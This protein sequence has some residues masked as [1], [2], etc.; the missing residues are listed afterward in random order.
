MIQEYG[1]NRRLWRLDDSQPTEYDEIQGLVHI[2]SGKLLR[3]PPSEVA[4]HATY[5]SDMIVAS[6]PFL[7]DSILRHGHPSQSRYRSKEEFDHDLWDFDKERFMRVG[8]ADPYTN[9]WDD[10]TSGDWTSK[11][12][13]MRSNKAKEKGGGEYE[14]DF[15][16]YKRS[17][18][19][20]PY[21]QPDGLSAVRSILVCIASCPR[22]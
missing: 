3:M 13:K 1:V 12:A 16:V 9:D 4:K 15:R 14:E 8:I 18:S 19:D 21:P 6:A 17:I 5:A 2:P 7:W 20:R 22:S 11:F 10:E